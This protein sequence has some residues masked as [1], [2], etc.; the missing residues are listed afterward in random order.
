MK[1]GRTQWVWCKD[2]EIKIIILDRN[3]LPCGFFDINNKINMANVWKAE[4]LKMFLG[5]FY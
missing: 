5:P 2:D 4:M 1:E 3:K